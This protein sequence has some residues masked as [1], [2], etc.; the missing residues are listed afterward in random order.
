MNPEGTYQWIGLNDPIPEGWE[1]ANESE[2]RHSR[3]GRLIKL[4]EESEE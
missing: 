4:I 3:Y 2:S 1:L